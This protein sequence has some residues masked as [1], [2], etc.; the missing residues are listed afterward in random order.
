MI[1]R[2]LA[3]DA[4][5]A[6]HCPPL[7][8]L[9]GIFAVHRQRV[10]GHVACLVACQEGDRFGDFPGAATVVSGRITLLPLIQEFQQRH[11]AVKILV[12]PT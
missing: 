8:R 3:A 7:S 5:A 10:S 11:P 9:R 1:A 4:A 12:G 6:G 2:L